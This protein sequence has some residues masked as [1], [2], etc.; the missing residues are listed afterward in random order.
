M[1]R[2]STLFLSLAALSLMGASCSV[3]DPENIHSGRWDELPSSEETTNPL[4]SSHISNVYS[5]NSGATYECGIPCHA[6][7][8][9]YNID[10]QISRLIQS[11]TVGDNY[12][13]SQDE[14]VNFDM[15]YDADGKLSRISVSPQRTYVADRISPLGNEMVDYWLYKTVVYDN[16]VE[17]KRGIESMTRI[18]TTSWDEYDSNWNQ[19]SHAQTVVEDMHFS[20][21]SDSHLTRI[22]LTDQNGNTTPCAYNWDGGKLTSAMLPDGTTVKYQYSNVRNLFGQWDPTLPYF[23]GLQILNFGAAP[24]FWV[25]AYEVQLPSETSSITVKTYYNLRDGV[26]N[27][28]MYKSSTNNTEASFNINYTSI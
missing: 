22:T 9:Q 16:I 19:T 6:M 11:R 17:G 14:D 28:Y 1:K 24:D 18:V 27:D 12:V 13:Y 15:T 2:N 26:L 20:Y 3:D 8:V 25:S 7:Q 5:Y 21:D 10:N 23:E 4:L